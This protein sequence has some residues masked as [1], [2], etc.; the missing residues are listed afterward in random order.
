MTRILTIIALMLATPAIEPFMNEEDEKNKAD[1]RPK[2]WAMEL[3][4]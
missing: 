3:M 4:K 1:E 2:D